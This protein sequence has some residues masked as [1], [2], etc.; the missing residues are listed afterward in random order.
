[1][2]HC[3][4]N[5]GSHPIGNVQN[6][7]C[8]P[9]LWLALQSG[10]YQDT[11]LAHILAHNT[12]V[13]GILAAYGSKAEPN[14]AMQLKLCGWCFVAGAKPQ[15]TSHQQ[16]MALLQGAKP[17]EHLYMTTHRRPGLSDFM[18]ASGV[19]LKINKANMISTLVLHVC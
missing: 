19:A 2:N 12:C 5:V 13:V 9:Q 3:R 10:D 11:K 15:N 1:M 7:H 14:L 16:S 17:S 18:M 6:G 4:L 8:L